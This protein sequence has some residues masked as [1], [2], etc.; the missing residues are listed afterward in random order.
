[1][2]PHG[3]E[4][5]MINWCVFVI[6]FDVQLTCIFELICFS[7]RRPLIPWEGCCP[8]QDTPVGLRGL[9]E[10]NFDVLRNTLFLEF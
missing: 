1:M 6:D 2:S 3:D 8:P 4:T 5:L 10:T 9:G 7:V